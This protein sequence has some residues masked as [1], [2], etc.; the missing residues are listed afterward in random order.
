MTVQNKRKLLSMM[1]FYIFAYLL[2]AWMKEDSCIFCIQFVEVS[3]YSLYKF[4]W[5]T[6][7]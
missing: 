5:I 2:N 1:L 7:E 4:H 6:H 3:S